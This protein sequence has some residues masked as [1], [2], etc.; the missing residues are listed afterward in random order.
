M[1]SCSI[2]SLILKADEEVPANKQ[3]LQLKLWLASNQP[4]KILRSSGVGWI[5]VKFREKPKK[6]LEAKAVWDEYEG[7][8]N[9]KYV[10]ELS[11]KY[12]VKGGRSILL[13]IVYVWT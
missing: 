13:S 5:A 1:T 2:I 8:K 4:S 3:M 11:D 9:M 6:V 7:E 10:N 12:N